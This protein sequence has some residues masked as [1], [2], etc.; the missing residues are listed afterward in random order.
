MSFQAEFGK[1]V[2]QTREKRGLKQNQLARLADIELRHIYNIENGLVEP[3]LRTVVVFSDI[4][5]LDLNVLKQY[6]AHDTDGIYWK[7]FD[8]KKQK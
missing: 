8:S 2:R 5:D 7:G 6:A 1:M 4:L 3:K